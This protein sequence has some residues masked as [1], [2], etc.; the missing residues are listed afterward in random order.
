MI[1]RLIELVNNFYKDTNPGNEETTKSLGEFCCFGYYDAMDIKKCESTDGEHKRSWEIVNEAVLKRLD[2]TCDSRIILCYGNDDDKDEKFWKC[3]ETSPFL[4]VTMVR[5]GDGETGMLEYQRQLMDKM[6]E[7]ENV[8]AYYS[9]SHCEMVVVR[10]TDRYEEGMKHVHVLQDKME[11][12]QMKIVK[13]YTISTVREDMLEHV[14]QMQEEVVSCRMRA[15]VKDKL[16]LKEF[17]EELR[18]KLKDTGLKM[19]VYET[20]GGSDVS[21]EIKGVS[22]RKLLACYKMGELLTHSNEIYGKAFYNVESEIFS[23]EWRI[24]WDN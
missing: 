11:H 19:K 1:I 5:L 23:E 13:L 22:L 20:L 16:F 7:E 21:I 14:D 18:K 12:V 10:H 9:D 8:I 2:G 6:N 15:V 3:A 4:F 24:P 17:L